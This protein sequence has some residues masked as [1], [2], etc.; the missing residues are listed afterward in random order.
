VVT[1]ASAAEAF[2]IRTMSF[3]EGLRRSIEES[4][5]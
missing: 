5:K 2:G 3:A 4:E 1:D